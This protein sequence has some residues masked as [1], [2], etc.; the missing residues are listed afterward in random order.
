MPPRRRGQTCTLDT[1]ATSPNDPQSIIAPSP[2]RHK[3]RIAGSHIYLSVR[4]IYCRRPLRSFRSLSDRRRP[5]LALAKPRCR[6]GLLTARH[7]M[8]SLPLAVPRP[9]QPACVRHIGVGALA[10]HRTAESW[11]QSA[12]PPGNGHVLLTG[13]SADGCFLNYST[14]IYSVEITRRLRNRDRSNHYVHRLVMRRTSKFPNILHRF[15][16]DFR[17]PSGGAQTER[18]FGTVDRLPGG[19]TIGAASCRHVMV[20]AS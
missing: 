17:S 12:R 19:E 6:V 11:R 1:L 16:S 9:G 10:S 14:W 15:I 4:S 2:R 7:G 13:C 8:K 20:M 3:R 5:S 18:R